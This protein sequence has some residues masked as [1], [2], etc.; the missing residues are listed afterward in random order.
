M[1]ASSKS[2]GKSKE[3]CGEGCS[4]SSMTESFQSIQSNP[5]TTMAWV[6]MAAAAAPMSYGGGF[7]EL[8]S[9]VGG[10]THNRMRDVVADDDD[11]HHLFM[12]QSFRVLAHC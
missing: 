11:D 10:T 3:A 8:S 9:A 6:T 4:S 1:Y 12:N 5:M 7:D 2:A